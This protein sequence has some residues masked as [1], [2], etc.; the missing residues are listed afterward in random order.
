MMHNTK[1]VFLLFLFLLIAFEFSYSQ[2]FKRV[3]GFPEHFIRPK[4]KVGTDYN[5][6]MVQR[7]SLSKSIPWIVVSDRTNNPT[8]NKPS[9]SSGE[10]ERLPF[11]GVYYV[12]EEEGEWVHIVNLGKKLIGGLDIK[13]GTALTD[14]GWIKKRNMLLWQTP[15]RNPVNGIILKSL[16]LYSA[17]A[18]VD[19]A[20]GDLGK[21]VKF[22][23]APLSNGQVLDDKLLYEFFF[24]LK[25][26]NGFV[27]LGSEA[28]F[29]DLKSNDPR[30]LGWISEV[31]Q[32]PWDTRLCLEP[33]FKPEAFKERKNRTDCRIH[34]YKQSVSASDNFRT[35][36]TRDYDGIYDPVVADPREIAKDGLRFKGY[37]MRLPVLK[38]DPS[39]KSE[40]FFSGA[41]GGLGSDGQF[42]LEDNDMAKIQSAFVAQKKKQSNWNIFFL[43]EA[44]ESMRA[45]K[46]A[47]IAALEN[48]RKEISSEE[49]VSFGVGFYRD[50]K[51]TGAPPFFSVKTRSRDLQ[52]IYKFIN[53]QEFIAEE[54][55]PHTALNY[56]IKQGLIKSGFGEDETNIFYLFAN[57]PD[58]SQDAMLDFKCNNIECPEK[59]TVDDISSLMQDKKVHFIS[60][61]P[62]ASDF[63]LARDMRDRIEDIMAE[64]SKRIFESN[65][66]VGK[67]L[68]SFVKFDN[69]RI[70][71]T[72]TGKTV[73]EGAFVSKLVHPETN[74]AGIGKQGFSDAISKSFSEI[75]ERTNSITEVLNKLILNGESA[76]D[77]KDDIS[78]G[79]FG[80]G[81]IDN[82]NDILK[83]AGY[84]EVSKSVINQI[85]Q[86][87][88]RLYQEV[89]VSRRSAGANYDA[90][91]PVLFFPREELRDYIN[92]LQNLSVLVEKN[93]IEMR[94][95]L[96]S[97]LE[98]LFSKY[99]GTKKMP[100][101]LNLED[102]CKA[103]AG[104]GFE[105]KRAD[106]FEISDLVKDNIQSDMIRSFIG[107]IT[108]KM[109]RLDKI[110]NNPKI[111]AEYIY[112]TPGSGE[113]YFWI[114]FEEVF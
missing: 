65:K 23:D 83:N 87:K 56:G 41:L 104:N 101:D 20:N 103:L 38:V 58:F 77:L 73:K 109:E 114:P 63:Y 113:N 69:P 55:D 1:K 60:I 34:L 31:K 106:N 48:I 40:W 94:R 43:I 33:N 75:K 53:Q 91:S 30:I 72:S 8:F 112:T 82:I 93:D 42:K 47:M 37:K 21:T 25:R 17:R 46:P 35:G 24:I 107:E 50:A 66:S 80:N 98:N 76:L 88:I 28:N 22:L 100:K 57:N 18:V 12:V 16:L 79:K 5:D 90:F 85:I 11:R 96:K 52:D 36:A 86:R 27:L 32:A 59:V 110:V 81:I 64:S 84:S 89:F 6:Y 45:W 13:L 14:R 9:E 71:E 7:S 4:D 10:K 49:N 19:I 29:S 51:L 74:S 39:P 26:E 92:E 99:S 54:V 61:Q 68:E 67:M 78:I 108:A 105:F 102:I 95:G 15:L 111:Y 2:D 62:S 97:H 70:I 44:S 3:L